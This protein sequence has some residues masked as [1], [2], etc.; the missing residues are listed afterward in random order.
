MKKVI[1]TFF[2]IANT[3]ILGFNTHFLCKEYPRTENL[4]F[5]YIGV[6]IGILSFLIAILAIMFGYKILD[7][8]KQIAVKI[9]KVKT[10]INSEISKV[11]TEMENTKRGIRTEIKDLDNRSK[12][13]TEAYACLMQ[14]EVYLSTHDYFTAYK[15]YI[16]AMVGF[17]I[18]EDFKHCEDIKFKIE[19]LI[20]QMRAN[21]DKLIR[22]WDLFND[23]SYIKD[24][25]V[26]RNS[27]PQIFWIDSD[28]GYEEIVKYFYDRSLTVLFDKYEFTL[29][30]K[31]TS[32][33]RSSAVYAL[34]DKADNG[35]Y[36]H[37]GR[38]YSLYD[39]FNNVIQKDLNSNFD[40]IGIREVID[41]DIA[42]KEA[43]EILKIQEGVIRIGKI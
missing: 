10:G 18:L 32:V 19:S 11:K 31:S 5:D 33:R 24:M 13:Y 9:S 28:I 36:K 7:V 27:H 39:D 12:I 42:K 2:L 23:S 8:D 4:G 16:E 3:I 34:L 26:L 17:S 25:E 14:G 37:N 22:D 1:N 38:V 40:Y 30:E 41:S 29:Y 35:N 6:I 20:R 43:A 21:R 15:E